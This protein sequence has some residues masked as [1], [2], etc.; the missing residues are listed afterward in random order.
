MTFGTTYCAISHLPIKDG[1]NC[2]LIPL[3]FCMNFN[4]DQFNKADVNCFLY[5]YKFIDA[6][7][8]VVYMGNPDELE[9]LNRRNSPNINKYE[10]YMLVHKKFYE[11]IQSEYDAIR[12][13][14][15]CEMLPNFKTCYDLWIHANEFM[16]EQRNRIWHSE[17]KGDITK[18]EAIVHISKIPTPT[19]IV[20]IYK[21]AM[22][23]DGLGMIPYPN[24][25]ADQH[26]RNKLYEKL[27]KQA[28]KK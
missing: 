10:L 20:E 16:D 26:E 7:Q 21:V 13:I 3:G 17:S 27:R 23:M 5:L 18:D 6:P 15:R 25:V 11:S 28:I 4:F 24:H 2:I 14:E 1:D 22:F 12:E 8:E 9:Y 19:W